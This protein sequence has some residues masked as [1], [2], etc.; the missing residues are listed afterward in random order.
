MWLLV[1]T[2]SAASDESV[3]AA[4]RAAAPRK[5][6]Q[7]EIGVKLQQITNV[8]QK[9]ENFGVVATLMMR[10]HAPTLAYNPDSDPCKCRIK[11]LKE[12]SF[13]QLLAEKGGRWPEFTIFNQQGNRFT[14]NRVIGI[15]PPNR[16]LTWAAFACI[17]SA[18]R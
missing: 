15:L 2:L 12:G 7:V 4:V 18:S 5:A 10:W 16:A 6:T 3:R 11:V 14:Q 17:S 9:V 13:D 8:D 1:P